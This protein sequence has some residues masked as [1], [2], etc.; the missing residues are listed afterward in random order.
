MEIEKQPQYHFVF[1]SVRGPLHAWAY[2]A[3]I[4]ISFIDRLE[5]FYRSFVK[6][7]P[8]HLYQN[9]II[10]RRDYDNDLI[11]DF[12]EVPIEW[13]GNPHYYHP[14]VLI[15]SQEHTLALTI[16]IREWLVQGRMEYDSGTILYRQNMRWGR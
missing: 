12:K 5:M 1:L 6:I 11:G 3:C 9:R 13:G 2:M 4:F 15:R 16:Y 8:Y 10:K 14:Q 7:D